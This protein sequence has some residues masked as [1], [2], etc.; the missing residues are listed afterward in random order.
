MLEGAKANLE[1]AERDVA[2]YTELIAKSATTQ[3]TLNNARTQVNIYRATVDSNIGQLENLNIQLSYCTI[4]APISGR[5]SM[6]LSRLT[7][8]EILALLEKQGGLRISAAGPLRRVSVARG[9]A[10]PSAA[11]SPHGGSAAVSFALKRADVRDL[12]AV[13]TDLDVSLAALGPQGFLGRLS[14]WTRDAPLLDLLIL[15][16]LGASWFRIYKLINDHLRARTEA[17]G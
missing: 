7:L 13:M 1:Q 2:R 8:D 9:S 16:F 12:L 4:R 5:A 15:A 6:D 17:E 10:P 11:P 14:I 3:V